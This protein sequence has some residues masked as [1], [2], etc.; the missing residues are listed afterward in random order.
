[1]SGEDHCLSLILKSVI[2]CSHA[3]V[4]GNIRF[5]EFILNASKY[6][7]LQMGIT[8]LL[9]RLRQAIKPLLQRFLLKTVWAGLVKDNEMRFFYVHPQLF[10]PLPF[11]DW[12]RLWFCG[13]KLLAKCQTQTESCT[14]ETALIK[15]HRHGNHQ[16]A[17][18]CQSGS[19]WFIFLFVW[20]AIYLWGWT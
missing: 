4:F 19:I 14:A 8:V 12:S 10:L 5:M 7:D 9:L 16:S 18:E 1:M 17:S 15:R 6:R 20:T 11:V 2:L 3:E 13:P